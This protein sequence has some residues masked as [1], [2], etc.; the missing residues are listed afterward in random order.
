[1]FTP[2]DNCIE[3][4]PYKSEDVLADPDAPIIEVG[5]VLSVGNSVQFLKVGDTV[6]FDKW[7][8]TKTAMRNGVQRYIVQVREGVIL[9]KEYGTKPLQDT[10]VAA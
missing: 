5:E 2:Y 1:M 10:G 6:Y 3:V 8:C 9:G 7:G 4:K